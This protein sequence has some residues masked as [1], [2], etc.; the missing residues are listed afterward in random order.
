ML[1]PLRFVTN[2]LFP[3]I[4][5]HVYA[6]HTADETLCVWSSTLKTKHTRCIQTAARKEA[7]EKAA[8]EAAARE[9]ELQKDEERLRQE[10]INLKRN[11]HSGHCL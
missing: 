8:A 10:A 1:F 6:S 7:E 2:H 5:L 4:L 3:S 9:D 11:L